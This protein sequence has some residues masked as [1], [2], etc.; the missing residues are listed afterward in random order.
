[1]VKALKITP[2]GLIVEVS[3]LFKDKDFKNME[4]DGCSLVVPAI[5]DYNKY[6]LSMFVEC[7][8]KN[9]NPSATWLFNNLT[10][11]YKISEC[12]NGTVFIANENED[13]EVD[14]TKQDLD[15]ILDKMKKIKRF[16]I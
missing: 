12:I 7:Y 13:V 15:Y 8:S 3:D 4:T 14:M 2:N 6:K 5:W 9:Y 11:F 10:S 16:I 1:M